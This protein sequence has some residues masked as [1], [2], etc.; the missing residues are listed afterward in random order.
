[1]SVF[2]QVCSALKGRKLPLENEKV[3]QGRME[4]IFTESAVEFDREFWLDKESKPDFMIDGVAVEV[5]ITGSRLEIYRQVQRYAKHEA[6]KAI[7]LVTNKSIGTIVLHENK[8]FKLIALNR[9]WL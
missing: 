3:L 9:S 5:K 6:V 8:P 2:N 1:M 7:I 4:E